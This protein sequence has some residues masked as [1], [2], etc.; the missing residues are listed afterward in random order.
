MRFMNRIIITIICSTL[1]CLLATAQ[2]N[3]ALKNASWVRIMHDD[4]TVNYF[5]AKKDFAKFVA[6]HHKKEA[7][8]K[9]EEKHTA[10]STERIPNEEH[11]RDPEENAIMAFERWSKSMRPFVMANGRVMSIEQRMA[12]INRGK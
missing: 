1:C 10:K 9:Q 11:L 4:T 2:K 5:T 7:E 6:Q 12:V 3:E 8:E